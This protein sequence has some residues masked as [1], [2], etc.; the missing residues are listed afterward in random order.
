MSILICGFCATCYRI[1]VIG[2]HNHKRRA[3]VG[4]FGA[5]GFEDALNKRGL[6]RAEVSLK[7][8]DIA[9]VKRLGKVASNVFGFFGGVGDVCGHSINIFCWGEFILVQYGLPQSH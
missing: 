3:G 2:L 4:F 7:E 6:S 1:H 8:D 5:E 9:T